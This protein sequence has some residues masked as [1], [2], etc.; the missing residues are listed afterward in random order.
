MKQ[1]KKEKVARYLFIF[2]ILFLFVIFFLVFNGSITGFA[3][4]GNNGA[5]MQ[6]ITIQQLDLS[7]EKIVEI[8]ENEGMG[9]EK[10]DITYLFTI[11]RISDTQINVNTNGAETSFSVGDE[12]II[13]LDNDG[14]DEL[15]VKL[16]STNIITNKAKLILRII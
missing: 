5:Y 16:I 12:K 1:N 4:R 7:N 11:E 8:N 2:S 3:V 10:N 15:Y 6:T 14:T 13:D 9:I